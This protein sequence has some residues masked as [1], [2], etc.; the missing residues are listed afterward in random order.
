MM[1]ALENNSNNSIVPIFIP[2]KVITVEMA[3]LR[4]QRTLSNC[5]QCLKNY[6]QSMRIVILDTNYRAY[7]GSWSQ[8]LPG[9]STVHAVLSWLVLVR[10]NIPRK[11]LHGDSLPSQSFEWCKTNPAFPFQSHGWYQ[12][13][14]ITAATYNTKHQLQITTNT[15]RCRLLITSVGVHLPLPFFV[16]PYFSPFPL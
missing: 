13:P 14:N 10:F 1:T 9:P 7:L 5:L 8:A 3:L 11:R 12:R 6:S 15:Y 4:G 2:H 16:V